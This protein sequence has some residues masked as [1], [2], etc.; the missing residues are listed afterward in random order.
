MKSCDYCGKENVEALTFCAE[1][2]TELSLPNSTPPPVPGMLPILNVKTATIIW[3]VTFVAQVIA[4]TLTILIASIFEPVKG[5][6]YFSNTM[7]QLHTLMPVMVM[8]SMIAGAAALFLTTSKFKLPIKDTSPAG[9]AWVLSSWET[10]IKGVGIG[11][12]ISMASRI[13]LHFSGRHLGYHQLD[14]LTRMAFKP[15]IS[16]TVY[17]FAAVVLAPPLEEMLYRGLLFGGFC[18][19]VGVDRAAIGTT[20]IFVLMHGPQLINQPLAT[21][22]ITAMAL[23]ALWMR[24]SNRSIGPAIA[25]HFGY[26]A[27]TT[28]GALMR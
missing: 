15:G 14:D 22:G 20:A 2:G 6:D 13:L 18:A 16:Q 28:L 26:N 3:I 24:L 10:I 4:G 1:C 5:D 9:A 25:V 12:L 23:A 27:L 8:M 7:G 11:M 21:L 19:S 17:V